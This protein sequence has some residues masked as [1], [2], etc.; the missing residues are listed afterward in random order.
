M[1]KETVTLIRSENI[2]S[3]RTAI[4]ID[5]GNFASFLIIPNDLK[6]SFSTN[7]NINNFQQTWLFRHKRSFWKEI[8]IK[9]GFFPVER[10]VKKLALREFPRLSLLWAESGQSV[11]LFLNEEPW[12]FFRDGEK[13]G[14]S[15]GILSSTIGSLWNQQL[16]EKIFNNSPSQS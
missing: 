8:K 16:F 4:A 3:L 11:A 14:Y 1:I 5:D 7:Q 12:A 15:K 10:N 9:Y 13:Q 6:N 2:I